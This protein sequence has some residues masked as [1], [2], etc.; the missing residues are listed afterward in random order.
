MRAIFPPAESARNHD[1][2]C[3][4]YRGVHRKPT[5]PAARAKR[6]AAAGPGA[7][8][9]ARSAGNA[10]ACGARIWRHCVHSGVPA[11]PHYAES[12]GLHR[13]GVHLAAHQ[14]SQEHADEGCDAAAAG[15]RAA[16]QRRGFL[17]A[18]TAAGAAGFSSHAHHRIRLDDGGMRE[19]AHDA[20][21]RRR[22]AR[23]R[24][25]NDGR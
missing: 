2:D 6:H 23:H 4:I 12:S 24:R 5:G 9:A 25:R 16:D 13:A 7:A 19:H 8:G 22:G 11:L 1:S 15:A 20:L 10:D 14:I 18:A 17:A 3:C 21:A